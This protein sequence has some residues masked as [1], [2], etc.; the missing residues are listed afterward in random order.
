MTDDE[1][2]AA[3]LEGLT[4]QRRCEKCDMVV[5]ASELFPAVLE[6]PSGPML[7]A[8]CWWGLPENAIIPVWRSR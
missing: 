3:V 6:P 5:H 4:D 8:D 7:C 2:A 1:Q